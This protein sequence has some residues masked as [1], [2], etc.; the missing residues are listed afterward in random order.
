MKHTVVSDKIS[1]LS[2]QCSDLV[3][4][5]DKRGLEAVSASATSCGICPDRVQTCQVPPKS[6][7]LFP[8]TLG[9]ELGL[10]RP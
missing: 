4:G 8:L 1:V 2:V 3:D 10:W 9:G 7:C 5:V 6:G